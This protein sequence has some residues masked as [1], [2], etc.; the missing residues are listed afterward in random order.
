MML[1][2][3][4]YQPFLIAESYVDAMCWINISKE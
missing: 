3:V 4:A 2:F 1:N